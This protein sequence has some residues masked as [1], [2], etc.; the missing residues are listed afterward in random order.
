MVQ[1]YAV[2]DLSTYE[3][4]PQIFRLRLPQKR[5]KLRSGG[6]LCFDANFRVRTLVSGSG[7]R[8]LRSRRDGGQRALR[9]G[10]DDYR[11]Q[12]IEGFIDADGVEFAL[13]VVA[14]LDE[15]L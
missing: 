13:G 6:Q 10:F 5:G 11:V 2:K 9:F 4:Q 15:L 8:V 14:L 7:A 1:N 3:E 12:L